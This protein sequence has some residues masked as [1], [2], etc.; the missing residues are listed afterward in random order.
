MEIKR[1]GAYG[2]LGTHLSDLQKLTG[3]LNTALRGSHTK[4]R[5]RWGELTLHRVAELAGMSEFCDFDRAGKQWTTDTGR[6]R[7]DMIVNLPGG[8][9]FRSRFESPA[10]SVPR[11][12]FRRNGGRTHQP[13]LSARQAGSGAHGAAGEAGLSGTVPAGA[14]YRGHVPARANRFLPRPWNRMDGCWKTPCR[15]ASC[16]R[17]RPC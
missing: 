6:Q 2:S 5:G 8:R 10:G 1:E 15:N 3:D 12:G 7:P 17:L 9:R 4:V 11:R 16:W 13:T 14:G